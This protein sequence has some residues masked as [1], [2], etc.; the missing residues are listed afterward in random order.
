MPDKKVWNSLEIAK[1][2]F[3]LGTPLALFWLSVT[4]QREATSEQRDKEA[5]AE[6]RAASER[7]AALAREELLRR[8]ARTSEA[9][10]RVEARGDARL[11]RD[12]AFQREKELRA[13]AFG[14]EKNLKEESYRKEEARRRQD[15]MRE[16]FDKQMQKKSE[17]WAQISPTARDITQKLS[18]FTWVQEPSS[19][20]LRNLRISA[21][22]LSYVIEAHLSY[23]SKDFA[24]VALDF[25]RSSVELAEVLIQ[26][27]EN[28][29][30]SRKELDKIGKMQRDH[31]K[32]YGL[33]IQAAT[34]ELSLPIPVI[35]LN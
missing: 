14:R 29:K 22:D 8:E 15:E 32:L 28:E 20:E 1:L 24:D 19:D 13:E 33:L 7:S 12:E 21:I 5:A 6:R 4:V 2:G 23:L 9:Q 18:K 11:A 16:L 26:Y 17:L 34:D 25:S 10:A 31:E 35:S 27:D 30:K 3:A